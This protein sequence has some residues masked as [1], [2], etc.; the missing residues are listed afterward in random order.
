[1]RLAGAEGSAWPARESTLDPPRPTQ[2]DRLAGPSFHAWGE[3]ASSLRS[4]P[5]TTDH[6]V[7]T[8][9][10]HLLIP[11]P[12]HHNLITKMISSAAPPFEQRVSRLGREAEIWPGGCAGGRSLIPRLPPLRGE[13]GAGGAAA[14]AGLPAAEA[15][16]EAP[17]RLAAGR[18][19]PFFSGE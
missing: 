12:R 5:R 4:A 2:K 14:A 9:P 7:P 3:E 19:P 11:T 17:A 15:A 10:K 18:V 8:L 1:M 13:K 6:W 16:V